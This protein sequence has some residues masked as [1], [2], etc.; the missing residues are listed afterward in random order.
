MR[1]LARAKNRVYTS[2]LNPSRFTIPPFG[3]KL[4]Q[5]IEDA[6]QESAED[7]AANRREDGA[8]SSVDLSSGAF[9]H[10]KME[11]AEGKGADGHGDSTLG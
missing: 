5:R 3:V 4:E 11:R 2:T 9:G 7:P 6:S 10:S 1:Q 8:Q